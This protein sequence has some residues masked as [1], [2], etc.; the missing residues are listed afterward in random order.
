MINDGRKWRAGVL[1]AILAFYSIPASL[2]ASGFSA[3]EAQCSLH[4]RNCTCPKACAR[5]SHHH[6]R[7]GPEAKGAAT[8]PA[9]KAVGSHCD[10]ASGPEAQSSS[11]AAAERPASPCTMSSC[12]KAEISLAAAGQAPYLPTDLTPL[13]ADAPPGAFLRATLEADPPKAG[14]APPVP[15]PQA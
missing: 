9:P 2:L 6:G 10:R 14:Q 1:A 15:P 11:T 8:P 5:E 3:E 13:P 12:G 7:H 4:G